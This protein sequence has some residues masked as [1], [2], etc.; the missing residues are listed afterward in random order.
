MAEVFKYNPFTRK[1]DLTDD[2]SGGGSGTGYTGVVTNF[3]ALPSP[4][5]ASGKFYYATN[6]QGTSWL[7][8]TLGG[9][10]YPN[11][12]YYSDGVQW[13]GGL[14][15]WQALQTDVDAGIITDQ[16][17]TPA[18]LKQWVINTNKVS[19]GGS[20]TDNAIVRFDGTTGR[21]V[22]NSLVTIDDLGGITFPDGI[23]FSTFTAGSVIFAGTGGLLSQ[24][25]TNFNW[26]NTNKTLKLSLTS[27]A[28]TGT[29]NNFNITGTFNPASGSVPYQGLLINPT[30]NQTVSAN[31]IIRGIYYNPTVTSVLGTHNAWESTAGHMVIGGSGNLTVTGSCSFGSTLITSNVLTLNNSL[32]NFTGST[33]STNPLINF[34]L[35]FNPASSSALSFIPI[36]LTNTIN[37]TGTANGIVSFVN[38]NPTL[39]RV[40]G[41]LYG[42]RSQIAAN[43]TGGGTAWNI[44]ADGTASNF[45]GG[46]VQL[47]QSSS[48]GTLI[49]Y[50]TATGGTAPII[51]VVQNRVTTTNATVTTLHT[52]ATSTDLNYKIYVEVSARRTGGSAGA[53]GDSG[54]MSGTIR[55]KNVSGT[56][57]TLNS[58]TDNS[59]AD[60]AWTIS[61]T[62]SGTNILLQVTGTVNNNVTWTLTEA[63]ILTAGS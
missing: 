5:L 51:S 31:G 62:T 33:G 53:V 34:T 20:A 49:Q 3:S 19:S 46:T 32:L 10:Y 56:L 60:Q 38:I 36:S 42:V 12:T 28:T 35:S 2:G 13:I 30:Y 14:S 50:T 15:P 11:G 1:L 8:G 55:V 18:T 59:S 48:G 37:Q 29:V 54:L 40:Q 44:Y 17:I 57:T 27:A 45:F 6:S 23:T 43:P 25:N 47:Q 63:K 7:P 58:T 4:A 61:W 41:T 52:F 22:Q 26:N 24:D 16:F 21:L 9:T 39:T